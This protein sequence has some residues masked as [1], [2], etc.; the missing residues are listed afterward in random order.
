MLFQRPPA[1]QKRS[2]DILVIDDEA[3]YAE[4]IANLLE[5]AGF[6]AE[7]R[8]S[9][10]TA[11]DALR[12]R[13]YSLVISDY[14]MPQIDGGEFLR[15]VRELHPTLP[16]IMISGYM[17][18]PELLKVANIGVTLVLEKPFDTGAFLEH[19]RRFAD[20]V[21]E[22]QAAQALPTRKTRGGGTPY[23]SGANLCSEASAEARE[24]L[25]S[26]WEALRNG[27]ATLVAPAG[28]EVDLALADAIKWMGLEPPALRLSPAL[29]KHQEAC[30]LPPGAL[31]VVDAREGATPVDALVHA[32]R[33]RLPPKS[34]LVVLLRSL[35]D[36][37]VAGLQIVQLPPLAGRSCDI[38]F[39]AQRAIERSG[40]GARLTVEAARVL[41][42]YAWPGNFQELTGALRRALTYS[43]GT[44]LQASDLEDAIEEGHGIIPAGV[45]LFTLESYL[46]RRQW[47]LLSGA[48]TAEAAEALKSAGVEHERAEHGKPLSQQP[49]LYPELIRGD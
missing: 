40:R 32:L 37:P 49:L 23:P 5:S 3:N 21:K 39:Y 42:N 35:P 19:V 14:K 8:T 28:S 16:V 10:T 9:P 4:M 43:D 45:E 29:L 7:M 12:Q 31:V 47:E 17:N 18:T 25:Q 26:F 36:V 30:D 41:L 1:M 34:P 2:D 6:R 33:E 22:T 13:S 46:K 20:P 48:G 27:G 15:Q 44:E 11:L 38:A 24:F